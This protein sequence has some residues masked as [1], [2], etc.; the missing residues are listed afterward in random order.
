MFFIK[1]FLYNS[2]KEPVSTYENLLDGLRNLILGKGQ[3]STTFD[4][5]ETDG[6]LGTSRQ[7]FYLHLTE[8]QESAQFQALQGNREK[9]GQIYF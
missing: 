9:R 8:L 4:D 1:T 6:A 3:A 7:T 5:I 2:S